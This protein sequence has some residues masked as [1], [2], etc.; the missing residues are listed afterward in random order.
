MFPSRSELHNLNSSQNPAWVAHFRPSLSS[1][2]LYTSEN[3]VCIRCSQA[4]LIPLVSL[5]HTLEMEDRKKGLPAFI[6]FFFVCFSPAWFVLLVRLWIFSSRSTAKAE[7]ILT[8]PLQ[9]KRICSIEVCTSQ[10]V[11]ER[12]R[13]AWI[14]QR[15]F[16]H[17]SCILV[18]AAF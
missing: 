15:P 13:V 1:L 3:I 14:T 18:V 9:T 2:I 8:S 16:P 4:N 10:S 11:P 7:P 5:T 17:F 12:A 6:L